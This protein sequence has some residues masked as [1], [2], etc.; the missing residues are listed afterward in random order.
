MSRL[1]AEKLIAQAYRI[2][3]LEQPDEVCV[4]QQQQQ[5]R[6]PPT[7]RGSFQGATGAAGRPHLVAR[8]SSRSAGAGLVPAALSHEFY[9]QQSGVQFYVEDLVKR[10]QEQRPEHPAAFIAA[11][12]AN[13]VKGTH[14]SGRAFEYVNGTLQNRAAFLTQLQKTFANVDMSMRT[15]VRVSWRSA[16]VDVLC[17][18]Q[19]LLHATER[20]ARDG[21]SLCYGCAAA[22][23]LTLEDFTELIWCQCR[24]FPAQLL[25]QAVHHLRDSDDS[26]QSVRATLRVFLASFSVCFFYNGMVRACCSLLRW[27]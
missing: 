27:H 3:S 5:Q 21:A 2:P 15:S 8:V 11:Y 4:Q 1:R 25:H 17:V 26:N 9:L 20:V 10:L 18:D 24:D 19:Q 7:S 6:H 16:M 13:V 23:E 22:A 14:V 12:F